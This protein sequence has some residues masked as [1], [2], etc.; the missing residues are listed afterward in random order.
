MGEKE[1]EIE[2]RGVNERER[3]TYIDSCKPT[4]GNDRNGKAR[5]QI[6]R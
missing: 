2:G 3:L 6:N 5:K 4:D 1:R